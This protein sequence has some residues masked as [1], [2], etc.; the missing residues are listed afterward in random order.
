MN[1]C[2][3]PISELEKLVDFDI[4]GETFREMYNTDMPSID[5]KVIFYDLHGWHSELAAVI[6]TKYMDGEN[7]WYLLT[8]GINR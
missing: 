6:W 2:N 3:I 7:V 5:Q 1:W 8:L 4:D